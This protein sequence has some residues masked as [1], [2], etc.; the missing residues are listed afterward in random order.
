[1]H[2]Q[3]LEGLQHNSRQSKNNRAA[4]FKSGKT[5]KS[6]TLSRAVDSHVQLAMRSSGKHE[7]LEQKR[8]SVRNKAMDLTD[9]IS[10]LEESA[11]QK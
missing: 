9:L 7:R 11:Q 5:A 1:M 8:V 6:P 10:R 3:A 4:T 2:Q